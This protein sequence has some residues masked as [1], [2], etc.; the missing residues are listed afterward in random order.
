MKKYK[1]ESAFSIHSFCEINEIIDHLLRLAFVRIRFEVTM[2]CDEFFVG[3]KIKYRARE[4]NKF[5]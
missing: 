2:R 1:T 4:A 3:E 5:P